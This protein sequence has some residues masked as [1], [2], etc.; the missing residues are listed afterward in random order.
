MYTAT[1]LY[2]FTDASFEEACALWRTRI[3]EHAKEQPGF[4]R[5]QLLTAPPRALAVGTWQSA[6]DARRFMET[7]VFKTLM[8]SLSGM[9]VGTPEQSVWELKFFA[10]R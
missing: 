10:G 5:M 7:G 3:L 9:V 2:R 4:V 8:A 6:E 1:M